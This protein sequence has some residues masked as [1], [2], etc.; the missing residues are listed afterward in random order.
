MK[1]ILRI[2]IAIAISL[3]NVILFAGCIDD[4]IDEYTPPTSTSNAHPSSSGGNSGGGGGRSSN[5]PPASVS[6]IR[7]LPESIVSSVYETFTIEI[8]CEPAQPI[9]G[10]ELSVSFDPTYLQLLNINYGDFFSGFP[11][12]PSYDI[13]IDNENGIATRIYNLIFGPGM[14]DD[15]GILISIEFYSKHSGLTLIS[16][17]DV[18]LTNDT[19]YL[20]LNVLNNAVRIFL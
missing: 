14:V 12:F 13:L 10:W 20:P 9:K 15:W 3:I 18:G 17:Y 4:P 8:R 6:T 11:T 2:K 16:L 5:N 1:G 7:I 19:M